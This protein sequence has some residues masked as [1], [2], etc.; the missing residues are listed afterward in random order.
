MYIDLR[1]HLCVIYVEP[2]SLE[3]LSQRLLKDS[4]DKDGQRFSKGKEELENY[5]SGM[6]NHFINLKILNLKGTAKEQAV[7]IY[8]KCLN[9]L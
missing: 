7:K 1:D 9:G 5:A 6:Y 3:K 8:Q 2:E 4:R